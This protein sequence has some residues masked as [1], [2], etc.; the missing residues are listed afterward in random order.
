MVPAAHL[1]SVNANYLQIASGVVSGLPM[2]DATVAVRP[3][4]PVTVLS[5]F[6]G[7]GKTTLLNHL[8]NN[9]EG[10]R[11]ALIVNDM[12]EVNVDA[13]LVAGTTVRRGEERLV[14]LSNG[15][16]CCTLRED[17]LKEVSAL[18]DEGR[19]DAIVIES[20]GIA[21]PLPIAETF[22]FEDESGARLNDKARLDTMVTVVD[23]AQFDPHLNSLQTLA[24]AGTG[25]DA[26]DDRTLANLLL[27][28]VEFADVL[29][30]NK[31]DLVDSVTADRVAAF[32][33]RVNPRAA[34]IGTRHGRVPLEAVIATGRFDMDQAA[35][36]PGWLRELRGE[37]M[38]ETEEYGIRSFV[39]R[40]RRPFHPGRFARWLAAE[41][42]AG[43]LRAKGFCWIASRHDEVGEFH[44]A[45]KTKTL[46]TLGRWWAAVP[47]AEWPTDPVYRG[48]LNKNLDPRF[49]DRR[50]EL[51]VI[52]TQFDREAI[53][54]SLDA[55]LLNDF[56]L[57]LGEARWAEF[58]DDLP[59][60]S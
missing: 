5:G 43:L 38:P 32:L 47:E 31:L 12:S 9:R 29:V 14:E 10:L 17:L 35:A 36:S 25:L 58:A 11:I 13:A 44:L 56:E 26:T 27:D 41:P 18:A 20:T 59:G 52:G 50:Q 3:P 49:G 34:L 53:T 46:R 39:Y 60:R 15:C 16:I 55:C 37:H 40:A 51:V 42:P 4:I 54:R 21:E 22:T 23:L 45:G 48:L 6:L 24:D 1:R 28:Q 8:L 2:I 57:H 19:Y 33:M 7:S 30:L